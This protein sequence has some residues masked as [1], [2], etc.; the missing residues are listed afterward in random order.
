MSNRMQRIF[1]GRIWEYLKNSL[2]TKN[3]DS[4]VYTPHELAQLSARL[5]LK[6][7]KVTV[8]RRFLQ[9]MLVGMGTIEHSQISEPAQMM[10]HAEA[11][12]DHYKD[13]NLELE[14]VRLLLEP[15]WAAILSKALRIVSKPFRAGR[16]EITS[17]QALDIYVRYYGIKPPKL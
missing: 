15:V 2:T 9:C 6:M 13:P 1:S 17:D 8:F 14:S 11:A 16:D 5:W 7:D 12:M 3:K 4:T 10:V